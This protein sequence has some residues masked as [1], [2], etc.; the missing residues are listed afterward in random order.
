MKNGV[1]VTLAMVFII[2]SC[3]LYGT[4]IIAM[5]ILSNSDYYNLAAL[6]RLLFSWGATYI[7]FEVESHRRE[8][9]GVW[10]LKWILIYI[11]G[12]QLVRAVFNFIIE[13]TIT[14]VEGVVLFVGLILTIFIAVKHWR[15]EHSR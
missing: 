1:Y 7:C 13:N 8:S 14:W 15:R 3:V 10:V 2:T 4:T 12:F 11:T 6:Y 9:S 5:P